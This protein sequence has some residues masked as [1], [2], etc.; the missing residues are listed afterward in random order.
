VNR[1]FKRLQLV[2][3]AFV[4]FTHGTNDA[5]KTMGVIALAL[6]ASGN[7]AADLTRLPAGDVLVF[8]LAALIAAVAFGAAG[9]PGAL[10]SRAP[11]R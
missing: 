3:G 6:V 11:R 7:L 4:A 8:S 2:S 10:R 5:Q 1:I 9:R